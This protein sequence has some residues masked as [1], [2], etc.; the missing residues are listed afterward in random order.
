MRYSVHAP[1]NRFIYKYIYIYILYTSYIYPPKHPVKRRSKHTSSLWKCPPR[2]QSW[3]LECSDVPWSKFR[4]EG[5]HTVMRCHEDRCLTTMN[6]VSC[7]R[8]C[9]E[10]R[11]ALYLRFSQVEDILCGN[12]LWELSQEALMVSEQ[13]WLDYLGIAMDDFGF[14]K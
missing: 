2:L 4:R 9:G 12:A 13:L 5:S 10:F 11:V 7:A 1:V 8:K 3:R 14:A 6:G